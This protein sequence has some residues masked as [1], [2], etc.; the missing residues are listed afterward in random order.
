MFILQS[1]YPA[2]LSVSPASYQPPASYDPT[3]EPVA[4]PT[5]T[6]SGVGTQISLTFLALLPV[7]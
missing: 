4:A 7:F 2:L 1:I 3:P 6:R 5:S